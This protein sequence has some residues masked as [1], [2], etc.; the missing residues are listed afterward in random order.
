MFAIER[1]GPL[2]VELVEDPAFQE[3]LVRDADLDGVVRGAPFFKPRVDQR[4]VERAPRPASPQVERPWGE[5]QRDPAR[6]RVRIQ[7]P[8]REERL[9]THHREVVVVDGLFDSFAAEGRDGVDDLRGEGWS[10]LR[11]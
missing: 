9:E 10:F 2:L 7:R 11:V 6:R 8:L 5:V 3:L 4:N 1:L